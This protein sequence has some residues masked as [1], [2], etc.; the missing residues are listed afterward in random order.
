[1]FNTFWG[2]FHKTIY[3]V[4]SSQKDRTMFL[5][6]NLRIKKN[7]EIYEVL[8]FWRKF[9]IINLTSYMA[10]SS[11]IQNKYQSWLLFSS[12]LLE[13]EEDIN[14]MKFRKTRVFK[15]RKVYF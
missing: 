8:T 6:Q 2:Q 4:F 5:N 10:F 11:H 9:K 1:M 12:V 13:H 14:E 15:D 7:K 3:D